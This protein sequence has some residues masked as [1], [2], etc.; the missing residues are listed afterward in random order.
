[1]SLSTSLIPLVLTVLMGTTAVAQ[2]RTPV[3][4]ERKARQL[5]LRAEEPPVL[6]PLHVAA[7]EVTT[8]T[9]DAPIVPES[10]DRSVLAPFFSRVAVHEDVLVLKASMDI[11]AG[12]EP[13]ITVRFAGPGAPAQ[14]GFV[15]TTVAAEVDSQVEVFRQGRTAQDL[16]KELADLR[17]RCA[18]TEAGL[19]TL[20]AQC[21]LRGLGGAV[22]MGD[23]TREGVAVTYLLKPSSSPGMTA[24]SP[25]VLYRTENTRAL[26]TSLINAVGSAPWIPGFA[27]M[28][29]RG[30][31]ALPAR[32]FP[33]LMHVKQLAPGEQATV[34]VEWPALPDL[35][36]GTSFTLE[37]LDAKG[38]R[39]VRW[40]QV[41]P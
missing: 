31:N 29:P 2:S 39:G 18:V 1:M 19:A 30:P 7:H 27:R 22:L 8:V 36:A 11:P 34:V 13:V 32:E 38:E 25:H 24:E 16:G 26:S 33:L 14:V 37:L 9:F 3:V 17:A 4:R 15:L 20:R 12:K 10:V 5:T 28:T 35:P 6:H 23:V 40:E 41:T 21:A